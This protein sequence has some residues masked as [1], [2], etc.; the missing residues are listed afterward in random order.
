MIV[1]KLSQYAKEHNVCYRTAWNWFRNG[2]IPNARQLPSSTIIVEINDEPDETTEKNKVVLYAR[3]SSSSNK[4]ML[5]D[6]L[7][8]L[9]L[10]AA[11]KG[12]VVADAIK[13][14][15]SGLNDTRQG[16]KNI[17]LNI[18][19]Y[20]KIIV[21]HRDRLTRFGFNWFQVFTGNKIE[22]INEAKKGSEQELVDD[23]IA[24]IHCFAAKTY[25]LRRKKRKI[26]K[27][28]MTNEEP[29]EM[30][31]PIADD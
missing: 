27:A 20:D 12:Y 29:L 14:Y 30:T 26:V 9:E 4:K 5:A 17:L 6:Q 3:T 1:K 18:H 7:E 21:E 10:Y 2:Q 11:S 23:L 28:I 19:K 13:E 16:L 8:R 22:V 31:S 24:I 25:G 15:G